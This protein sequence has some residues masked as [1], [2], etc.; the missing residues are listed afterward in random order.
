MLLSFSFILLSLLSLILFYFGTGKDKR[1]FSFFAIWQLIIGSVALTGFFE[2]HPL[3]LPAVMFGTIVLTIYIL[4]KIKYQKPSISLLLSIHIL[5]IP[6]E[7]ILFILFLNGK[8][9]KLMTFEGWNFDI[10]SGITALILLLY[11]LFSRKSIPKIVLQLWNFMGL[12][13]L[14]T[15]VTLAILSAPLPIQQFAFD[16]PNIAVLSFPYCHL[17]TC[18][19]PIVLMSHILLLRKT[20]N[21]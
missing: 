1:L 5:R 14:F 19:V 21:S 4:R 15:I 17:A 16:Q 10:I 8:I 2:K 9:P 11:V 13:L 6:V 7:L 12:I 3:S 18:V 20:H